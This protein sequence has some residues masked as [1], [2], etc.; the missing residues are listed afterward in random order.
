MVI[1]SKLLLKALNDRK[2]LS[3]KTLKACP[4]AMQEIWHTRL[5][6][7]NEMIALVEALSRDK[8]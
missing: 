6:V 1:D 7:I 8:N 2:K 3:I 5:L 4:G